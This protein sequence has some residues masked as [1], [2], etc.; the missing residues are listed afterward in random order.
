VLALLCAGGH[1]LQGRAADLL[2][3][4]KALDGDFHFDHLDDS[5]TCHN[6]P[7]VVQALNLMAVLNPRMHPRGHRWR[8][9]P[10]RDR[11]T[12]DHGLCP[13]PFLNGERLRPA[14]ASSWPRS[15]AKIDTGAAKR[16]AAKL[17]A[18]APYEVLIIGGGPAGAAAAVYAA[19][20][21]I[22]TGVVAER[23]GGQ[24]MDTL[25]DREL[26]LGAANR[27]AR[28]SPPRWKRHVRDYERGRDDAA[29]RQA[30]VDPAAHRGRP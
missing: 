21:G 5:L 2:E 11:S 28:S 27:R 18:K 26:H 30:R 25:D 1:P 20:K 24:T 10:G 9:V 13:R 16:E 17:S 4:I 3:Q 19:R 6:C 15:S 8:P 7:D 22:R 14:A 12:P 23:F 29:A